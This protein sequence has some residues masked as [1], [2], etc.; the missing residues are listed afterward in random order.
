MDLLFVVRCLNNFAS[1]LLS[2]VHL[3]WGVAV[4]E[5]LFDFSLVGWNSELAWAGRLNPNHS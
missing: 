2:F 4:A 1:A 5:L 3:Q